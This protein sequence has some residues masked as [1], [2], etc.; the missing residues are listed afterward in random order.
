[1]DIKRNRL[2]YLLQE[3]YLHNQY[4]EQCYDDYS[5]IC[6]SEYTDYFENIKKFLEVARDYILN[7]DENKDNMEDLENLEE[8]EEQFIFDN[9]NSNNTE[10]FE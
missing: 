7:D 6:S 4:L 2:N 10:K 3:R 1:M 8:I 9:D 5:Q